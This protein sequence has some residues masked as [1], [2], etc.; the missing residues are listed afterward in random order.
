MG[1]VEGRRKEGRNPAV[2]VGHWCGSQLGKCSE[3]RLPARTWAKAV[4]TVCTTLEEVQVMVGTAALDSALV[5]RLVLMYT[6]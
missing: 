6:T 1:V 3:R 5:R 2:R 4:S